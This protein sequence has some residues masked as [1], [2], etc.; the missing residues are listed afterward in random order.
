MRTNGI[1]GVADVRKIGLEVL[2]ERSRH[3]DD[4]GIDLGDS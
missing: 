3:T 2:V 4:D 1:E